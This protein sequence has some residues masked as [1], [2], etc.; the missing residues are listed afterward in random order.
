MAVRGPIGSILPF[1]FV[2]NRILG[3]VYSHDGNGDAP[4]TASLLEFR[5]LLLEI[6]NHSINLLDHCLGENLEF[7][8]Y[9]DGSNRAASD[10]KAL[11]QFGRFARYEF[12][13]G[14]IAPA[15]TDALPSITTIQYPFVRRDARR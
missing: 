1:A 9:F 13:K 11:V 6:A 8:T 2:S 14:S 5:D 15:G 12:S 7:G 3:V 4:F 10:V